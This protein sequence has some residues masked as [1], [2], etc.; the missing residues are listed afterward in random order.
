MTRF[1][2]TELY[3]NV[4]GSEAVEAMIKLARQYWFEKKQPQRTNFIARQLSYHGN[5]FSTL[6]LGHHPGRRVP[7]EDILDHDNFHH[8]GPAYYR[9][10]AREGESEEEYVQRLKDEL[11]AKF[12]Q[13]GGDTVIGCMLDSF[14]A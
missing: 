5:T 3:N 9:H 12:Q 7:Y 10:Y 8:V 14:W 6:A 1:G 11:D 4:L 13:L 2:R